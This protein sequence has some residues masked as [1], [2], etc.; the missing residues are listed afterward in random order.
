MREKKRLR[1]CTQP[2]KNDR[3]GV[4]Q[5][6]SDPECSH[7]LSSPTGARS[8]VRLDSSR[9][10][11]HEVPMRLIGLAVILTLSL[12]AAPLVIEAQSAGN[13]PRIG[14]LQ[15]ARNENVGVFMQALREAGYIDGQTAVVETRIYEGSL[16]QLP[17]LVQE[18][19]ALKCDAIVA[20]AP[21][22]IRA[23]MRATSS[24]PIVGIDLESDPVTSGWAASI[25]RPGRNLTGLFLD[26]PEL[27]GKQI[28]LLKEAVPKLSR[29]GVLWDSSIGEVQFRTT[30]TVGQAAGFSVQSLPV[31]RRGD[32]SNA[33]A[34]AAR[35]R[36]DG[37]VILP[38]PLINEQRSQIATLALKNRLPTISLFTTFPASGTLMAYG[39]SL[40]ELY[41]RAPSYV[42]K[43][44][45]G[46][47]PADLP[48]ERPTKF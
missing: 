16:E 42:D 17:Q 34:Q 10:H 7:V 5:L 29:V 48:I 38:S 31:Q 25:N 9:H 20:A 44:L 46:A 28:Q 39:P 1:D 19:M 32:F 3:F 35:E 33:F 24:I 4:G 23:A 12:P 21:Y 47:K 37:V 43:I 30:E 27:G 40:Q 13:V 26:L 14:F 18:L 22:A 15:R 41:R 6:P 11:L 36:S 45:K 8:S 2:P